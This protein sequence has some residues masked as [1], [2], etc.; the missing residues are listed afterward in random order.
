MSAPKKV[1]VLGGRAED[2]LTAAFELTRPELA[3][4]YDVTV[5]QMGWRLGGKGAS[6]RNQKIANRIEEH[7]LHLWMGFYD[8]AFTVM[9]EA[10]AE[11]NRTSGPLQT[12]T[13]A[14]KQHSYIA[15][16]EQF[17]GGWQRWQ[18]IFPT[19]GCTPGVGDEPTPWE[20]TALII[21]WLLKSWTE[22]PP[23]LRAP[24]APIPTMPPQHRACVER[25]TPVAPALRVERELGCFGTIARGPTQA[26]DGASDPIGT[27]LAQAHAVA[28]SVPP[29][30]VPTVEQSNCI[31]WIIQTLMD[32]AWA[33]LQ[34]SVTTSFPAFQLWV[35]IN[36]GGSAVCGILTDGLLTKPWASIDD[37]DLR[38]WLG[39]NGANA[40][41]LGSSPVRAVY[42]LVFGYV[43]GSTKE[44]RFAAGTAMSGM[45]RMLCTYKGSIFYKMQA[46]MGDTVFTPLYTVL[47][48]RGVKF[49]FFHR[50]DTV[51]ANT[52]EVD[53]ID[54]TVQAKA[55]AGAYEPLFDVLGLPCWPSKP[56][57]A[58]LEH[59]DELEQSG[60]DLESAWAPRWKYSTP[61]TLTRG[62]DFD[63][64]VLGIAIGAFPYV[65]KELID[66]SPCFKAMV[67]NV[68]T[69]ETCAFQ[70]WLTP[71][72][73]GLG[74]QDPSQTTE[75][76][77]VGAFYEP[78]DTWADM[79]QLLVRETW[80]APG[81]QNVAYFC[82]PFAQ[83]GPPPPFT[84]HEFPTRELARL[85]AM[86][87]D[88]LKSDI[89]ALWPMT[90]TG[91]AFHWNLLFDL[92]EQQ[93]EARF[94]S[95]F[96]RVNIDP[97]ERYVL[98]VPGSTQYRLRA[99]ES[100][101]ANVF[102]A[103]DWTACGV[104]AGCVEAAVTSGML[105]ATA[106]TGP[107]RRIAWSSGV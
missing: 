42:D 9:Q 8:N 38:T 93:G 2:A 84:D 4:Q 25:A 29:D 12:W 47:A 85:D 34:G 106:I 64:V 92:R 54:L 102:L 72:L 103:G 5:Y 10:Y 87:I 76:P 11:M 46:G 48:K 1:A 56:L 28:S 14:F 23:T 60:I 104:N 39:R 71:D 32:C 13:D 100:G 101:F 15:L 59:G 50:V 22:A 6:G 40:T 80:E 43:G 7:G 58:K 77:V 99:N 95:Q 62:T 16:E 86:A 91:G 37:V 67:D 49:E 97:T 53:S 3:G 27:L 66:A 18:C 83:H 44:A 17:A 30:G 20:L 61:K 26:V 75:R 52:T 24:N 79:S 98:S 19:N 81:P 35:A 90:T 33:L 69:A 96:R 94:F 31:V 57:F 107:T 65:A 82:G 70:L 21:R 36:L 45:L 73:T 68:Q 55:K 74:W 89:G 51:H 88:F 105:A 41:T 63:L 78:L